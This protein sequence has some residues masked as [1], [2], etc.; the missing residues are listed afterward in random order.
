VCAGVL[1]WPRG[2]IRYDVG[3][4][5]GFDADQRR[6]VGRGVSALANPGATS[7]MLA[8]SSSRFRSWIGGVSPDEVVA[9]FP[10]WTL[11]TVEQAQTGALGW[12]M[13]R[14]SPC[15]YRLRIAS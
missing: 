10:D 1:R 3:C 9:A 5:Q 7:L 11:D 15:W 13:N 2:R 14:T 12:P 6:A 8:F 4:F